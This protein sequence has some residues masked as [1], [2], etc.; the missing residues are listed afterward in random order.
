MEV[1]LKLMLPNLEFD[2]NVGTKDFKEIIFLRDNQMVHLEDLHLKVH[3][4]VH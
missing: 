4:G 1:L 3:L 2:T